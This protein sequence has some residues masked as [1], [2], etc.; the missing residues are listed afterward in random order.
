MCGEGIQEGTMPLALLSAGFQSLPPLPTSKLGPSGADSWVVGLCMFCDPV[1][2][3]NDL[4]CEAG[5]SPTATSTTT[6]VFNQRFEALFPCAGTL[7]CAVCLAPKL[8]LP[9]YLHANVVPPSLQS[10]NTLL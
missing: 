9:V 1:G 7:G 6:G 8:F 5:I 3:C 10:A 4:S 2:L